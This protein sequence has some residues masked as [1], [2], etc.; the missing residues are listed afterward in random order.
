MPW[1]APA[2][3]RAGAPLPGSAFYYAVAARPARARQLRLLVTT[4]YFWPESF[5]INDVVR[6]LRERGHDLEVLT[7]MP[8]Y[9]GGSLY[10]G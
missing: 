9:P 3:E 2:F 4:Q 8:N 1:N 7:A 5:R 10:P 6:G